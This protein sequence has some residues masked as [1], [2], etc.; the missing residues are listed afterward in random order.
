MGE[1]SVAFA[2]AHMECIATCLDDDFVW[3]R[4]PHGLVVRGKAAARA[5]LQQ[6]FLDD[7]A[8]APVFSD[9]RLEYSGELAIMR[10]RRQVPASGGTKKVDAAGLE[11][12]RVV[13]GK[14]RSK[15]AYWKQVSWPDAR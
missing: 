14:I 6:R 4:P 7:K 9:V 1:F 10:C 8:N 2:C 11:V 5:Y 3:T 15:E 13:N 12:Y